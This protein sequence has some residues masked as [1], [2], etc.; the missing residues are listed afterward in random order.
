[1]VM[2]MLVPVASPAAAAAAAAAAAGAAVAAAGTEVWI[3]HS[4]FAALV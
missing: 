2:G 1:M 3:L 4:G